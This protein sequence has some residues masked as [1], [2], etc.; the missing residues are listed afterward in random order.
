MC[1]S[2]ST[3]SP[4]TCVMR[5]PSRRPS[6]YATLEMSTWSTK[7]CTVY[8]SEISPQYTLIDL[9]TNG[10]ECPIR[11]NLMLFAADV[12]LYCVPLPL[13]PRNDDDSYEPPLSRSSAVER[14]S[15]RLRLCGSGVRISGEPDAAFGDWWPTRDV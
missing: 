5:S 15:L 7:C 8:R 4:F 13:R 1:S 9:N 12:L 11:L 2:P 6:S 10:N 14:L 3:D